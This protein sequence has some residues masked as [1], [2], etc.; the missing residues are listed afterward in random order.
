MK[1]RFNLLP[2][3]LLFI[4]S[5]ALHAQTNISLNKLLKGDTAYGFSVKAV[6]LNASSQAMGARFVHT[7]TGFTIDL[8]Q[9]E[10]V[11]Q[12]FIYAN[13]FPTSDKGEPHT[14]EH[15]L[16]TKGNKGRDLSMAKDMSVSNYNAFTSQLHTAYHF[17]TGAGPDVFYS[18]F[19][20]YMD[21]LLKPNYSDEEVHREV[22][23]WGVVESPDK[24]L[25][26][27]EKG[28]VYM[29]M[30]T[31]TDNPDNLLYYHMID[32]L[33]GKPHPLSLNSGGDP[34]GIRILNE[35][36]ISAFHK[37]NYW[38]GNMGAIISL[39]SSIPVSEAL[40]KMN[41]ICKN[42]DNGS[43]D[44]PKKSADLSESLHPAET[45]TIRVVPVPTDDL[46][47][48]GSMYFAY[49]PLLILSISEYMELDNFMTAFAGDPSSTLNKVFVDSKTKLPNM[50]A[51]DVSYA[52][53]NFGEAIHPVIISITGIKPE[54]LTKEKAEL[55]R[56]RILEQLKIIAA[57]PDHSPELM[58]FNKRVENSL[59]ST[60]RYYNYMLNNP[61]RFGYRNTGDAWYD[62]FF[63]LSQTSDFKKSLV[64]TSQIDSIKKRMA[65]GANI[66]REDLAKWRLISV[67]PYVLFSKASPALKAEEENEAKQ[68]ADEEVK[69]LEKMYNFHDEQQAIRHYQMLYDSN[70]IALERLSQSGHI[71]FIDNPPLTRDDQL[72]YNQKKILGKIPALNVVFNNMTNATAG[73][74]ISLNSVKE[75]QLVLLAML[76]EL[77]TQTGYIKNGQAI[78][79]DEMQQEIQ[80]QIQS[81]TSYFTTS[82]NTGRAELIVKA[83]GNNASESIRAVEWMGNVLYHPN[84]EPG[85][86]SRIRDLINQTLS[87]LRNKML[88]NEERWI[89]DPI[90]AYR[91]QDQPL[92]LATS[93]FLTREH[94][95]F[96]LKWMLKDSGNPEDGLA[97]HSFL[98][99]LQNASTKR[100]DMAELLDFMRSENP[101]LSDSSLSKNPVAKLFLQLA[102]F[103]KSV[104][105]EAANDLAQISINMPDSSLDVD[106]KYLCGVIRYGLEQGPIKTLEMLNSLR[107]GL[108]NEN[109]SRVFLI[110]SA[111]TDSILTS[112]LDKLVSDFNQSEFVQYIYSSGRIIDGRLKERLHTS[113]PVIFAGLINPD[114]KTGVMSNSAPLFRLTDTSR[115]QLLNYLATELYAG[116]GSQSVYARVISSGLSYGGGIGPL[117]AAGR[118]SFSVQKTPELQQTLQFVIN[119][120]KHASYDSSMLG[121]VLSLAVSGIRSP[122]NYDLRGEQMSFDLTEG[123]NPEII[124][125]FRTAILKLGKEPGVMK[126]IYSRK[127]QVNEMVLPGY[128]IPSS[129]VMGGSFFVIG[130][131]HQMALY[132]A[133]LKSSSNGPNTKLY[134]LYPRDFWM[135]EK[136]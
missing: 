3:T 89:G 62:L 124:R 106:W 58:N 7:L 13:S 127:D 35:K 1:L 111:Q 78:S 121:H 67:S 103:P 33:Y 45:G 29:E 96:R 24:T 28:S 42:L 110:G 88:G 101:A 56:T 55:T 105:R 77:L 108:L 82:V 117:Q 52:V 16:I 61:P 6:Y 66:W 113:E 47:K 119:E 86:L 20:K 50:D 51:Q 94:N 126:E 84:W 63:Q 136:N 70:T 81:L 31:G 90:T 130:P 49:P 23:N 74:A 69:R 64:F 122:D 109:G 75:N 17:Y 133:Y 40:I 15:L 72:I 128:G 120:L 118:Y 114:S 80:N 21:A 48:S 65:G 87:E 73:I 102:P 112:A 132:E 19:E 5:L 14:Q 83:S 11:P 36:D 129:Q 18:L 131:E 46:T 38:L 134:R 76:P 59:V 107:K 100:K 10:S 91:R 41:Q 44:H 2:I 27:Q 32:M 135:V 92:V 12:A 53:D 99:S 125:A 4:Q 25:R 22:R 57:Y 71:K 54:Y 116:S 34:A 60:V 43:D 30:L 85:N 68:R 9:I 97:I 39:P 26:L 79:Y 37:N 95:I 93:S 115:D 98:T 123:S 8:L 104:A